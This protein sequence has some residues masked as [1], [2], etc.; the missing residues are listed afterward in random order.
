MVGTVEEFGRFA[1]G[2]DMGHRF[3][4]DWPG[5]RCGAQCKRTGE[6]CRAPAVSGS[7]RCR[8]HGGKSH[9]PV[10]DDGKLR[11]R[12]ASTTHGRYAKP[13]NPVNPDGEPGDLW[14]RRQTVAERRK[15]CWEWREAERQLR[16]AL[17]RLGE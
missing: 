8:L 4:P 14:L 17:R 1:P 3:G 16:Q 11:S 9:G 15:A 5:R 6:P 10:T 2:N 12:L 7:N 13:G